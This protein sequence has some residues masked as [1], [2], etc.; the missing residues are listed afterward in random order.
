ML[1]NGANI[2]GQCSIKA[3]CFFIFRVNN[4]DAEALG[5]KPEAR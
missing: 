5:Y 2:Y 3:A 4:T 1:I